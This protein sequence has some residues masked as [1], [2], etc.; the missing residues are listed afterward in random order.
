[1]LT[2]DPELP[3]CDRLDLLFKGARVAD[4]TGNPWFRADVGVAAGRVVGIGDLQGAKTRRLVDAGKRVLCPG[5]IDLLGTSDWL[6][7]KDARAASKVAQG[8]TLMVAAR[9]SRRGP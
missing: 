1:M 3:S 8:I 9:S 6:L 2:N 4:G 7:L 5:F